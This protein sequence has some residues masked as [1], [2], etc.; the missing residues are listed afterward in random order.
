MS[1]PL[2]SLLFAALV[3]AN[4]TAVAAEWHHPLSL[5]NHGYWRARIPVRVTNGSTNVIAG[6]PIVLR[7]PELTGANASSIRVC[8]G[9][10]VELLFD[11]AR[12][13]A[14]HPGN[15]WAAEDRLVVPVECG[16]AATNALFVYFDNPDAWPVPDFLNAKGAT[17]GNAALQAQVGSVERITLSTAERAKRT[18]PSGQTLAVARVY[19]TGEAALDRVLVLVDLRPTL[20]RWMKIQPDAGVTVVDAA[21]GREIAGAFRSR[22]EMLFSATLP[23]RSMREFRLQLSTNAQPGDAMLAAYARLLASPANR[24]PNPSFENGEQGWRFSGDRKRFMPALAQDGQFGGH[25]ARFVVPTN[26]AASWAGWQ[27]AEIPVRP[28]ASYLYSGFIKAAPGASPPSLHAHWHD[29]NGKVA[30]SGYAS[31]APAGGSGEWAQSSALMQAPPD[32]ATIQL[33]LTVNAPGTL[34]HDGILFC[35]VARGEVIGF[36]TPEDPADGAAFRVAQVNP[37][38]KVFADDPPPPRSGRITLECARNEYEPAQ[39]VVTSARTLTNLRVTA[40]ALRNDAGG[41]LPEVKVERVGFVPV[42]HPSSYYSTKAEPWQRKLPF[43][44]GRTDGWAGDW[45]D[46]LAPVGVGVDIPA[47]RNQPFWLTVKTLPETAAGEYRGQVTIEADGAPSVHVPIIARVLPFALPAR[48]QLRAILDYRYGPGGRFGEPRSPEERRKWLRF[49]AEYRL[50]I[51]QI[52]PEPVFTYTNG[53]VS[54]DARGFDE[55]ARYCF[56]ELGMNVSYTP[57]QFYMFGWAYPPKKLFGLEPFSPAWIDAFKQAYGL[58]TRHVRERGWH[59]KFVYYI[60]DEPHF[61]HEFVVDQMKRLCALIHEVD[62]TIPIYSSTWRHCAAWDQ[63]LDL[64][65]VGQYGCFPVPELEQVRR[66]GKGY[67]FTCDGEMATDT[68]YLATERMLPYYCQKYGARGFEF[69]GLAW[70]TYDPWTTG[71]HTFI[72]QSDDG[73]TYYWTRYPNGDGYLAYPGRS[74]GV[75]GP[76]STIR[77]EQIREGLEDFEAISILKEAVAVAKGAGRSAVEGE[78][79]LAMV[80]NL[81]SIPNAG[82][83]RSTEILPNP[84]AIPAIRR[85]VNAAIVNLSGGG[86]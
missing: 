1:D 44:A 77:L 22:N 25:S 65:G 5:A 52:E 82:G 69:W 70:W 16:A 32:A 33:H 71:W 80:E 56:D 36:E 45:P 38:I 76:V 72:R 51:D 39:M 53:V 4:A 11:V 14:R 75:D 30:S 58:F 81:V 48:S 41:T 54:M 34:Q 40:S 43:G 68:P 29:R 27:T 35:E 31:T 42:D 85:A 64:W 62:S 79:A 10:G 2:R 57:R 49:M 66:A 28:G 86:K 73:K 19:N 6:E 59:E 60:S 18:S 61:D 83:L 23:A 13:D 84:D 50:G 55:T 20:G 74:V 12:V 24:A 26:A 9:A 17:S 78:R 8:T 21:T 37:L 7:L 67:W 15:L 46:P 47:V 3:L 63:S